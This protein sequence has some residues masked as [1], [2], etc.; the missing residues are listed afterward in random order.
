MSPIRQTQG[1]KLGS[2]SWKFT[3]ET[4][5]EFNIPEEVLS[6]SWNRILLATPRVRAV[7]EYP[8][9][10]G[11]V[12]DFAGL[13]KFL[14]EDA[15]KSGA[16]ILVG[17]AVKDLIIEGEHII[18]VSYR[19]AL[20][21]GEVCARVIVDATGHHAFGN[22]KLHLHEMR[23]EHFAEAMEYQ[24]TNHPAELKH[25]L[26][27]YVGSEYAP[28]GYAW[29][30][31]MNKDNDAKVGICRIGPL[32]EGQNLGMF[33][34][35]FIASL[36]FFQ[37]MEPTEIHAGAACLDGGIHEHVHKNILFVGDSAHQ[38]NPLAGE[39][40][41]HALWAGRLA[42]VAIR[43]HVHDGIADFEQL[44]KDYESRWHHEFAR[45]WRL[46]H[47]FH[48]YVYLKFDDKGLDR[49]IEILQHV[50]PPDIFKIL[51]HYDFERFLRYP[52]VVKELLELEVDVVRALM[53]R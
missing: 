22:S 7:W 42:A 38:I 1:D 49:F 17:T 11:Y 3:K 13:R 34:E 50:S 45:K 53:K 8:E 41:R 12:F 29:V 37:H 24:M 9:T 31:P 26:A 21:S 25:T 30:Y 48:K 44:K 10:V 46:S 32:P 15:A 23:A 36:P 2:Y 35:R 27:N 52:H 5:D 40:I 20:G 28:H 14:A 43:E 33:Q 47:L 19:G 16:E 4:I 6:A 39:G 51:F 18:G